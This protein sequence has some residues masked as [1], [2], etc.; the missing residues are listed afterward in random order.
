MFDRFTERAR[1]C[2]FFARYEASVFGSPQIDTEHLLLGILREDKTIL[3]GFPLGTNAAIRKR[4]EELKPPG[5]KTSTSIDL[6]VSPETMKVIGLATAESA[7][8]HHSFIDSGHL[9]LGLLRA[10]NCLAAQLLQEQGMDY[11]KFRT[12]VS[13]SVPPVQPPSVERH[14]APPL[15]PAAASRELSIYTLESLVSATFDDVQRQ[16][17]AFANQRLKR[18]PWTRKE[19]FGHLID[20]A[21]AHHEWFLRALTE[22]RVVAPV[23]PSDEWVLAQHYSDYP[24]QE[25]VDLWV[26]LNNLLIHVLARIPEDK[27]KTP[28]RIGIEEPIPLSELIARYVAHCEDIV[29]QILAHL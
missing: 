18:K 29:G 9:V 20:W 8:L 21:T 11:P 2:I 5:P 28:C 6:P 22:P 23:Y 1:R 26:A 10:V 15:E 27:L 19:A 17:E 14:P 25:T 13:K 4:I 16:P 7:A 3:M 12:V 24:W